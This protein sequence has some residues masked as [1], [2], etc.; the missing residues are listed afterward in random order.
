MPTPARDQQNRIP[1]TPR[2]SYIEVS[3]ERTP[4]SKSMYYSTVAL[5]VRILQRHGWGHAKCA[6]YLLVGACG[7]ATQPTQLRATTPI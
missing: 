3:R 4:T 2:L 5:Q 6:G 1:V 7:L